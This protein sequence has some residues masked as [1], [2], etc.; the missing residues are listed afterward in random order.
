MGSWLLASAGFCLLWGLSVVSRALCPKHHYSA[1][2]L[3]V[4][5]CIG[6]WGLCM[7]TPW[8]SR[9]KKKK[10]I[11]KYQGRE[12]S[13]HMHFT[14]PAQDLAVCVYSGKENVSNWDPQLNP[15]TFWIL[16]KT[17]HGTKKGFSLLFS[18]FCL[19]ACF[20]EE[21]FSRSLP[22]CNL[23]RVFECACK[24]LLCLVDWKRSEKDW[25]WGEEGNHSQSLQTFYKSFKFFDSLWL[26]YIQTLCKNR[27]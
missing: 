22:C 2:S 7:Q 21:R 25:G 19:F 1:L 11:M 8:T 10:E 13:C 24:S 17:R 15:A 12:K 18:V 23:L 9:K 26:K 5:R 4:G 14:Q 16:L 20:Q 3:A 6:H 27:N